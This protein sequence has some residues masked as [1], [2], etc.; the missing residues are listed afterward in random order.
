M[1]KVIL[2]FQGLPDTEE[3]G[4]HLQHLVDN[5]KDITGFLLL[6]TCKD[7]GAMQLLCSISPLELVALLTVF[8]EKHPKI[9]ML[10]DM[11]KMMRG[12][13]INGRRRMFGI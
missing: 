13:G 9:V 7:G 5:A 1:V 12:G 10:K 8:E 3:A 4:R 6:A 2:D 11:S